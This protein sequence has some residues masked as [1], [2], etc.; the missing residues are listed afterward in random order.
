MYDGNLLIAFGH[1][2]AGPSTPSSATI[3][4]ALRGRAA[5]IAADR[6][7]WHCAGEPCGS[8]RDWNSG[9]QRAADIFGATRW[10]L[11]NMYDIVLLLVGCLASSRLLGHGL[12]DLA[13]C[14][15]FGLSSVSLVGV[16]WALCGLFAWRVRKQACQILRCI[17]VTYGAPFPLPSPHANPREH[18]RYPIKQLANHEST[19]SLGQS[20]SSCYNSSRS[21]Y[22]GRGSQGN[23][24]IRRSSNNSCS[25]SC[26]CC[27]GSTGIGNQ[28]PSEG[29]LPR[30]SG[31]CGGQQGIQS[32][33][34]GRGSTTT[35]FT[36]TGKG[37]S[38]CTC[39]TRTSIRASSK[40]HLEFVSG[41]WRRQRPRRCRRRC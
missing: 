25:N 12:L 17:A 6:L 14:S 33:A 20:S 39:S 36:S 11:I 34:G 5:T 24:N 29:R 28:G 31:N 30:G 40:Q 9:L 7:L 38:T 35:S 10:H 18:C 21:S 1:I 16:G 27:R 23:D 37:K 2:I 41:G 4:L 26:H 8:R 19:S 15:G 3:T 22:R 13:W 32:R